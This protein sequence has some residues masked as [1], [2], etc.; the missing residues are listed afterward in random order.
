MRHH[1]GIPPSGGERRSKLG[2][3]NLLKRPIPAG[4]KEFL[5][6][7]RFER[8]SRAI[9]GKISPEIFRLIY[10]EN[11]WGGSGKGSHLPEIIEPYC[12]SVLEFTRA[13]SSPLDAV[14]L[15]CG[16]FVVGSKVRKLFGAY[17]AGDV[18]AG[19]IDQNRRKYSGHNV[20]FRLLD[21]SEDDLPDGDVVFIRQVLQ[22]LS[23][24]EISAILERVCTKYPRLI[25]TEHL[26]VSPD[27]EPNIDKEAG[28]G[29]RLNVN[30]GIIIECE[31]FNVEYRS[32]RLMCNVFVPAGGLVG[33]PWD[34]RITTTLYEF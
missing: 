27:F 22:H 20:D 15:G 14:D 7:R 9:E 19:V 31:P 23:N 8:Y 11:I 13:F 26:P 10:A 21:M 32:A 28:H 12:A 30:S 5:W 24:A 34:S 6:H 1:F 17:V 18:V 4:F 16:D 25:L 2:I 33:L 29:I 3:P